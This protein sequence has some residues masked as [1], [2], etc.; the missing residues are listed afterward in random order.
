[1]YQHAPFPADLAEGEAD[2]WTF[3]PVE[4]AAQ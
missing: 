3:P 2:D 4:E 1:M